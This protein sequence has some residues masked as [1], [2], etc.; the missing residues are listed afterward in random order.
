M[1]KSL[2]KERGKRFS[3]WE[4][5]EKIESSEEGVECREDDGLSIKITRTED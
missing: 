5:D 4:I 2:K 1:M 3:K